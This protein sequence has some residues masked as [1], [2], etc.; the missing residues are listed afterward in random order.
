M[1]PD[2]DNQPL[3]IVVIG[4]GANS[5][6]DVA[7]ASAA[8]ITRAIAELG[9]TPSPLTI[10]RDGSWSDS[11]GP[12][13]T[14][15]AATILS[16][17]DLVF[18]ALHGANGEDGAAAGLCALLG[19]P[20]IGS[21][22]RAGAVAMEKHVTKLLAESIGI[23]CA[24]GVVV[25]ESSDRSAAASMPLPV[26]VKPVAAGSSFGVQYVDDAG[27]LDDAIDAAFT[28][29]RVVLVEEFIDGRE[30]DIA[31]YRSSEGSLVAGSSLEIDLATGTVF[32]TEQKYAGEP[33]FTI[34]ANLSTSEAEQLERAAKQ[35]YEMLGCA[36]IAR[37]DFFLTN[38]GLVLN[39]V[40]TMPG[41]T[42]S[43]Q[44]PRMFAAKGLSYP[45]LVAEL[46]DAALVAAATPRSSELR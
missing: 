46:I 15:A 23:T 19:V 44:V 3:H 24:R 28:F 7:L 14:A 35:L 33:P 41:F 9:H 12:I 42:P 38:K 43:S 27:A 45:A 22:V 31:V 10:E 37:F 26:V 6:H 16:A 25:L 40:N 11:E 32:D 34:P 8:A 21:P 17:A 36:G 18:P 2:R 1:T 39:E 30:I 5:E 4:G 13:D 29:D 20:M